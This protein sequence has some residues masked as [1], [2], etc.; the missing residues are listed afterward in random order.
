MN[1]TRHIHHALVMPKARTL[2]AL[3]T[4]IG[5]GVSLGNLP[6][7]ERVAQAHR[8]FRGTKGQNIEVNNLWNIIKKHTCPVCGGLKLRAKSGTCSI[9]CGMNGRETGQRTWN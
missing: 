9:I 6:T 4:A 1:L 5:V 3:L 7:L 8:I 2:S